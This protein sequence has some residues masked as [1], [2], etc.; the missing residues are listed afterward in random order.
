MYIVLQ[1]S[2]DIL[3]FLWGSFGCIFLSSKNI[4][5][6]KSHEE[7]R[8]QVFLPSGVIAPLMGGRQELVGLIPELSGN[9]PPWL[10]QLNRP[11]HFPALPVLVG[12]NWVCI[13]WNG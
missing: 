10:E 1:I 11:L 9:P 7:K 6:A 3:L 12:N 4:I 8:I 5:E 2:V 13:V